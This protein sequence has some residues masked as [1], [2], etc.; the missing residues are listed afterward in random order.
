DRLLLLGEVAHEVAG[1]VRVEPIVLLQPR[2]RAVAA[3]GDLAD[4]GAER[5]AELDRPPRP[6]AAPERQLAGLA[7]RGRDDDAIARDL[8]DAPGRRAEEERLPGAALVH[9]LLVELA[10]ARPTGADVH[11]IEPAV[12]DGAARGHRDEPRVAPGLDDVLDAVP[13]DARP[14]IGELVGRV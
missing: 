14:E 1:G 11:G 4:E 9:H 8:L 7:R 13:D 5:T 6:L 2:G 10:D 3:R 12:G